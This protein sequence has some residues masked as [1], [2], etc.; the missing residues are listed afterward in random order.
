MVCCKVITEILENTSSRAYDSD[1]NVHVDRVHND[2]NRDS[3]N[4]V[5]DITIN[6]I[7]WRLLHIV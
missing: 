1:C 4:V 2:E 3:N 5:V 7:R 6:M